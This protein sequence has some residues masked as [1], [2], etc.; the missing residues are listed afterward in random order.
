M[1]SLTMYIDLKEM[2]SKKQ[3][4]LNEIGYFLGVGNKSKCDV[5]H[6]E[7]AKAL[8]M[9][10]IQEIINDGVDH[11]TFLSAV[12]DGIKS[13]WNKEI[14]KVDVLL[15]LRAIDKILHEDDYSIENDEDINKFFLN[16]S[17]KIS[18]TSFEE[19]VKTILNSLAGFYEGIMPL[20]RYM[21]FAGTMGKKTDDKVTDKE[22]S[23]DNPDCSEN[24]CLTIL[25]I[26][27]RMQEKLQADWISS[28]NEITSSLQ[29]IQPDIATI[30]KTIMDFT[31]T[32][33]EKFVL[34]LVDLL[35]ELYNLLYDGYVSHKEYAY[36]SNNK[37]YQNAVEN[38]VAYMDSIADIMTSFG[39]EEIYSNPGDEFDP[40]LHE[41]SEYPNLGRKTA[42]IKDH[43]KSGFVYKDNIIQ[44][45]LVTLE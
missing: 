1:D 42:I 31:Q 22:D 3:S 35:L 26:R 15:L 7:Q 32:T 38:Y 37:N 12:T 23:S 39:I 18:V 13:G 20:R 41:T 19:E 33:D 44:K 40:H 29:A 14:R 16:S 11:S 17:K 9:C 34:R 36:T 24:M 5:S 21:H 10:I 27:K 30:L 4:P 25:Q 8:T 2:S 28:Q 6:F 45:E 43:L